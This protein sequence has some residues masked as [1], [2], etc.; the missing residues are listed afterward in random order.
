VEGQQ[1]EAKALRYLERQV[2][3]VD[4]G[5]LAQR[6]NLRASQSG[7]LSDITE[8]VRFCTA[9]GRRP[10]TDRDSPAGL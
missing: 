2:A 8:C 5:P 3:K 7:A 10:R 1:R 6:V 4:T 9:S